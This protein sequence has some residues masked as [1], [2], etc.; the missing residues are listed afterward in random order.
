M[1]S[2]TGDGAPKDL[3]DKAD[4]EDESTR[5]DQPLPPAQQ[6]IADRVAAIRAERRAAYLDSTPDEHHPD[7]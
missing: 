3:R 5:V 4:E 7:L 1:S 6:E 2:L